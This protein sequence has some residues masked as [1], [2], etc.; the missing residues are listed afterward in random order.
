MAVRGHRLL[1]GEMK[2]G[3]KIALSYQMRVDE[4]GAL[5]P[6]LKKDEVTWEIALITDRQIDDQNGAMEESPRL[7]ATLTL[8]RPGHEQQVRVYYVALGAFPRYPHLSEVKTVDGDQPL[9]LIIE[10]PTTDDED[11]DY[12]G[13]LRDPDGDPAVLRF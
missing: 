2:V 5:T 12:Y 3:A 6:I 11:D 13:A 7:T 1:N 4:Q 8:R 10:A 9:W